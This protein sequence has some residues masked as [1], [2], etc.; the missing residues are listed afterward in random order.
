M[1]TGDSTP[2]VFT[3]INGLVAAFLDDIADRPVPVDAGPVLGEIR[4]AVAI[5]SANTAMALKLIELF[6][7]DE[8]L[9]TSQKRMCRDSELAPVTPP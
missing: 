7:N 1:D 4:Q 9:K 3:D 6:P 2:D 5:G 8:N